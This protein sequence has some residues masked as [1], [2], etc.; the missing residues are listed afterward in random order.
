LGRAVLFL[1][2]Q[3]TFA[4]DQ[5]KVFIETGKIIKSALITQLLYTKVVFDQQLA[6]VADTEFEEEATSSTSE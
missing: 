5:F 4:G 6:G 1:I 2:F 3:R